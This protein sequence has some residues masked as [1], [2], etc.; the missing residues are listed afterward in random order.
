MPVY[1]YVCQACGRRFSRF[2][3]RISDAE[4]ASCRCG[5]THLEQQV[6]R[7]AMLRSE[8]SRME[9][10]ADPAQWS[11]CD[12]NDPRAMARMMRKLGNEMGEDLG[13]EF[14]EVV[15]RLEAGEDPDSIDSALSGDGSTE[16]AADP[17]NLF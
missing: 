17:D 5:S 3:W 1:E 13:P 15:D 6:S 16:T 2:F 7:V 4:G 9:N 12:E 10:L 8:E 14:G 11:G